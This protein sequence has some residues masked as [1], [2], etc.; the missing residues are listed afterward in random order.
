MA[1]GERILI[2]AISGRALAQSARAGGFV[3]VVL[4]RFGDDDTRSLAAGG[5]TVAAAANAPL[6]PTSVLRAA[7]AV[8]PPPLPLVYGSGFDG[9]PQLLADLT[10]G[11]ELLGNPP[12]TVAAVK[13]PLGFAATCRRL[14]VPH[15]E[16]ASAPPPDPRGWLVKRRGGAGGS[17]VR[18]ASATTNVTGD[19]YFQRRVAGRAV[20]TLL[21]GDGRRCTVLAASRQWQ[22][23]RERRHYSGALFPAGLT[24]AVERALRGASIA[25]G[26]AY[27]LRGLCSADFLLAEDG[28]FHLLEVN[29]RPGAS[30][31]AAELHLGTSLLALHVAA[32]RGRLPLTA[33]APRPGVAATEIV[34]A[35][36]DLS[37]PERFPWPR[38]AG[39]HTPVGTALRRGD[40]VAT[41]RA[42]AADER[43]ARALLAARNAA[44][45]RLLANGANST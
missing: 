11:R 9:A 36:R 28:S 29:P 4:D 30:L 39:D 10:I 6:S 31:E 35:E 44:L 12:G 5:A 20:S 45:R 8:A 19:D 7:A 2:C 23:P 15:P 18:Q 37:M 17:H 40:P 33:P 25:I 16:V 41:I 38:W 1:S 24:P 27:G 34:W 13:D 22:R 26:E 32:V 3:P 21:L 42:R 14:G 43:M